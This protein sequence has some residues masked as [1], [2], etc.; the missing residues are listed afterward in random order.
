MMK[1]S[2][3]STKNTVKTLLHGAGRLILK[4]TLPV[5]RSSSKLFYL[6]LKLKLRYFQAT[7]LKY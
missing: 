1:E 6:S 7:W 5:Y 2:V 4:A 3:Q